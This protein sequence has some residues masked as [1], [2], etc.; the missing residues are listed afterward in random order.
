MIRIVRDRTQGAGGILN[1]SANLAR[2]SG[3]QNCLEF[4]QLRRGYINTDKVHYC[5]TQEAQTFYL[6]MLASQGA[7]REAKKWLTGTASLRIS[8]QN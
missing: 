4:S 8:Y 6:M 5:L 2:V 3:L 7:Y 1:S